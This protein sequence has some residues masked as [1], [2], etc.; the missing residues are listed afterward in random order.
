MCN[1]L[2][3]HFRERPLRPWVAINLNYEFVGKL[4]GQNNLKIPFIIGFST[5]PASSLLLRPQLCLDQRRS[6]GRGI[7]RSALWLW[8]YGLS[9]LNHSLRN[10]MGGPSSFE[11]K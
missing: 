8:L 2:R 5:P 10:T 4:Q 3:L 1:S 6:R 7:T 11:T 9:F